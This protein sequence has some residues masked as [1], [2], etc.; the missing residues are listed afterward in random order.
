MAQIPS[1]GVRCSPQ[2]ADFNRSGSGEQNWGDLENHVLSSAATE[3]LVQFAGP[4]LDNK[5]EVFFGAVGGR[6]KIRAKIPSRFWKV[7][8]A[9]TADGLAAFGFVLEQDLSG[10][11]FEY[12]PAAAFVPHMYRLSDIEAMTGLQFADSISK[13]DQ[14]DTV[15]G[16]EVSVRSGA[17]RKK[18]KN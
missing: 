9:K 4:V 18:L 3:K 16:T 10:F 8:V 15:R 2:T 11:E 6:N 5:D 1:A 13:A 12:V 7:I 14:Y 17:R